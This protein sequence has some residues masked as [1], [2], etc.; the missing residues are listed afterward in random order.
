[1]IRIALVLLL[2]VAPTELNA[3]DASLSDA[4]PR[5]GARSVLFA[6]VDSAFLDMAVLPDE[7]AYPEI[8][9]SSMD[10]R[11][12]AV[13]GAVIG[14]LAGGITLAGV[15]LYYFRGEGRLNGALYA[16]AFG[17][18]GAVLGGVVGGII[19]ALVGGPQKEEGR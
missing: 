10:R 1:M 7:A 15:A 9:M 5:M 2:V 13:R 3:Q 17:A 8:L 19:G 16:G 6:P 4:W 12:G 18:Q 11:R 14:A